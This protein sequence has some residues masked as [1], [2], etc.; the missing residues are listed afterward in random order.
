MKQ[1]ILISFALL[2]VLISLAA[3]GGGS[4][5]PADSAAPAANTPATA[6]GQ[7][8]TSGAADAPAPPTPTPVPPTPTPEATDEPL[9]AEQLAA[10]EALDSYRVLSTYV[11]KGTDAE[12]K[13]IDDWVEITMEVTKNPPARHMVMLFTDNTDPQLQNQTSEMFQVGQDMYMYGGEESGWIRITTQETPFDSPELS[14]ITSGDIFGKPEELKRVR[15]DEKING[16]DSRHYQFDEKA[17]AKLLD[18][19]AGQVTAKGD[20]WVAKDGGYVTKYVTTIEVKNGNGGFLDPSMVN[21][22]IEMTY[23]LQEVNSNIKIELPAAATAGVT[24]PGF[25]AKGFPVPPE[26][27]TQ[28]AGGQMTML[29][30]KTSPDEVAAFYE[31]ALA[32]MGWTKDTQASM[33]FQGMSSLTFTKDGVILSLIIT[34]DESTGLTQI[35]ANI[36]Q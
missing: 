10:A 29:Q 25:E 35:M 20:V 18:K 12:G 34:K 3:C 9:S 5:E 36:Q 21:G 32:D 23:E 16:I 26:S 11:S 22:S 28:M 30:S 6:R 15:P 2:V 7:Q 27:T 17:L 33:S 19:A 31:S 8:S 13:A 14:M 4:K 24:M 1:R